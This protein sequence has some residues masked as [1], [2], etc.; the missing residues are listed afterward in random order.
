MERLD[1]LVFAH[2]RV[3]AA[4]CTAVAVLLLVTAID[5]DGDTH[6]AVVLAHDLDAGTTVSADDVDEVDLAQ[7]P[8]GA[9]TDVSDV[10]G[11]VLTGPARDGEVV[12]DRRVVD[13]RD[14]SGYAIEDPALATVRVADPA[15]LVALRLGDRVDVIA[16]DP[17]GETD[18][19]TIAEGA[20]V[21]TVPSE[22]ETD[23]IGVVAPSQVT[24]QI[25]AASLSSG[26]TVIAR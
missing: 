8:Q 9:L 23:V 11:R 19:R 12:T 4:I 5:D 7:V 24:A 26:L 2:R 10:V 22:Q 18:P 6:P 16:V 17:H 25:A 20:V 1:G 21:V 13:A 15:A 3:L 14:L